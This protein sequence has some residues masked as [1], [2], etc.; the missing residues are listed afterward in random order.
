[1][2]PNPLEQLRDIHLP[3]DP[4]WW[5]PAIGWWLVALLIA[6]VC[7]VGIRAV[8]RH[9]HRR[10]PIRQ[11][12]RLYEQLSEHRASGSL[13]AEAF[14]HECNE[15]LKRLLVHGFGERAARAA[16]D[17]TWLTMLDEHYGER[18]FTTGP[19][20]LLGNERFRPNP[21]FATDD[22]DALMQRF[23]KRVHP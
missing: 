19:G 1:M 3:P 21:D 17:A 2:Q 22:L 8:Y 11:A 16:T 15:L 12:R 13:S 7:A 20:R 14:A 4:G 6:I 23:L 9:W 18:A 10:R 5:P